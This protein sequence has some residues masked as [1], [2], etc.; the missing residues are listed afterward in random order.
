MSHRDVTFQP[1]AVG[2]QD[3]KSPLLTEAMT[4]R[5][6]SGTDPFGWNL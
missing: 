1:M 3:Y 6:W 5:G 2:R 4:S